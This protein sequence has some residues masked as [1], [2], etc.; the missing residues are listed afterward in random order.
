MPPKNIIV[1][2]KWVEADIFKDI[3]N[4]CSIRTAAKNNGMSEG[5]L[6]L[7][8]KMKE[9]GK[10]LVGSGRQQ[11]LSKEM[12]KELAEC[13]AAMNRTG[14]SPTKDDIKDLVK[15]FVEINNIKTPFKDNR[16]GK[17]WLNAFLNRNRLSM[18]KACL[19]SSAQKSA[20]ENP[21]VIYDFF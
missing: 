20:T 15:E 9:E 13:L 4:G 19:I 10:E 1:K 21:F 7:R 11:A 18:K 3:D 2:K 6:R 16:P 17:D 5:I 14:F 8:I 12:E